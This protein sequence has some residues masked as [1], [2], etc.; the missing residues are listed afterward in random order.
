MKTVY[1]NLA[2]EKKDTFWVIYNNIPEHQNFYEE[3]YVN[4][5][6]TLD[7]I[8]KLIDSWDEI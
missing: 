5:Y 3:F 6:P 8:K 1:K 4:E 7:S 2:I